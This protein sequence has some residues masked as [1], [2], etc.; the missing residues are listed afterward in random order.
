MG[1]GAIYANIESGVK[2][3]RLLGGIGVIM[4]DCTRDL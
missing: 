2:A 3:F 1:T 4:V